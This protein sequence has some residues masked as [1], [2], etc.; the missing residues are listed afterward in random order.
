MVEYAHEVTEAARRLNERA[1]ALSRPLFKGPPKNELQEKR[2]ETMRQNRVLLRG[3]FEVLP[4]FQGREVWDVVKVENGEHRLYAKGLIWFAE[5]LELAR[6]CMSGK[7]F[8]SLAGARAL[9]T[10]GQNSA[11]ALPSR[12]LGFGK[13]FHL[14]SHDGKAPGRGS[15]LVELRPGSPEVFVPTQG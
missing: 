3:R 7:T 15:K 8:V 4:G 9:L 12:D 11:F 6:A 2:R 10:A 13:G 14:V 1:A 5:A